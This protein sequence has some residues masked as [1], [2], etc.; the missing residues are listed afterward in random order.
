MSHDIASQ[1]QRTMRGLGKKQSEG[2][3]SVAAANMAHFARGPM[4][5]VLFAPW[6]TEVACDRLGENTRKTVL[7]PRESA[8]T[9]EGCAGRGDQ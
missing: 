4:T 2:M 6:G 9:C 1:V 5:A 8:A 3:R 7:W